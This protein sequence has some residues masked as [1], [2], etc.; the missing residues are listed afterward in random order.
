MHTSSQLHAHPPDQTKRD[1]FP[2]VV[3]AERAYRGLT[4]AFMLLL[5]ASL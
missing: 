4:L 2:S 3:C 5:L 1:I